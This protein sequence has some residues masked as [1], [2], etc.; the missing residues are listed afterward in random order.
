MQA[1]IFAIERIINNTSLLSNISLGYDIRDHSGN[2]SKAVKLV[3]K[4]LTVDSCVNLSQNALRKK[5][6][7]S[8]IG[9]DESSTILFIGGFLRMLNISSISGS[10]TS[11][12]LSSLTYKQRNLFCTAL[13]ELVRLESQHLS[14][15]NLVR[16]LKQMNNVKVVILR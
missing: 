1:M 6:I 12:E 13:T 15:P 16:K 10:A 7:I 4:L 8:L 11:A 9:P 5:V 2:L 3:Y 14:I